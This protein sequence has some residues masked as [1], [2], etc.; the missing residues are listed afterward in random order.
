MV[1]LGF[2]IFSCCACGHKFPCNAMG[3]TATREAKRRRMSL[4]CGHF[5]FTCRLEGSLELRD[6]EDAMQ[7]MTIPFWD[8]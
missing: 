4:P 1:D 5:L 3:Q 8:W 7:T 6:S 2:V